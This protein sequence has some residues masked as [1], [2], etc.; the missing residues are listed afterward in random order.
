MEKLAPEGPRR[1]AFLKNASRFFVWTSNFLSPCLASFC[2][3][4]LIR[5]SIHLY[6]ARVNPR[7]ALCW[8]TLPVAIFAFQ[9]RAQATQPTTRVAPLAS[10][11]KLTETQYE[12][13]AKE[14]RA[15]YTQPSD[16]W[17]AAVIDPGVKHR[18]IGLLPA[19][20]FPKDNSDSKEKEELGKILFFDPRLSGSGQ[21]ACASCHDPDLAWADGRTVAFGHDRSPLKRNAPSVFFSAFLKP[22]FWDG[23]ADS[24]EDQFSGP[25]TAHDEMN[26][27]ADVVAKRLDDIPEYRQLFKDAFGAD[28]V[29]LK[30]ASRAV[31][32]FERSLA[33]LVGRSRFDHFL[34]G[35]RNALTDSAI[36]GLDL[37]RT[38]ARCMN[39]H[40]G[41]EFTDNQF[42]DLGLSYYG[43]KLQDLGRYEITKKAEDMGRFRTPTLRDVGRT[44]PYM[45]N[46]LFDLPGVI[47]MYNAGMATLRRKDDELNDPLFPTKDPLL[48]PL[49][50]NEQDRADLQAFLE[51]LSEPPLRIRPP[52]LPR[53]EQNLP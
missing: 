43:R 24:L 23:R 38:T 30:D 34:K 18:E 36:R 2:I 53:I 20:E 31:A 52:Q 11:P 26:A 14:L 3:R 1:D 44:R 10:R 19:V 42:H 48:H 6:D 13:R 49:G 12:A 37:F 15:T 8:F 29:T 22:L 9:I 46:G 50:L 40:N 51:S 17:P 21:I 41:P 39:C 45:H 27:N 4:T 25:I 28:H 7:I 35:Q 47:N 16:Q 5:R 32:T 33:K